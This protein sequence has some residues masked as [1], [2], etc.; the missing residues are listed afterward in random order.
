MAERFRNFYYLDA[1]SLEFHPQDAYLKMSIKDTIGYDSLTFESD[2]LTKPTE[3]E[4]NT[5]VDNYNTNIFPY[6]LLR[7][8]RNRLLQDSDFMASSDRPEMSQAWKDYRQALRDLPENE[9]PVLDPDDN[10]ET[11]KGVTWPEK[12]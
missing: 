9:T 11:I 3:E 2:S 7:D 4:F 10:W 6:R 5:L 8:E 1:L 12:P